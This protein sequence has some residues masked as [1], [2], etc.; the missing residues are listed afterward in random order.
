MIEP[1]LGEDLYEKMIDVF[2]RGLEAM[3]AEAAQDGSGGAA[4]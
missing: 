3:G 1:G 2:L 4:Q